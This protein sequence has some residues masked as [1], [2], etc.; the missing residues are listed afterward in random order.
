MVVFLAPLFSEV[1]AHWN[2]FR[3][4]IIYDF[5]QAYHNFNTFHINQQLK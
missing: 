5:M 1:L 3:T 4:E 2:I